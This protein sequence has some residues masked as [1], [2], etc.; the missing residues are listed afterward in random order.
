[1]G[2]GIPKEVVSLQA[3]AEQLTKQIN[4]LQQKKT[5]VMNDL[6]TKSQPLLKPLQEQAKTLLDERAKLVTAKQELNAQINAVDLK[7]API[8]SQRVAY[9]EVVKS[10]KGNGKGNNNGQVR[11]DVEACF[12]KLS[13]NGKVTKTA[14]AMALCELRGTTDSTNKRQVDIYCEVDNSDVVVAM[15]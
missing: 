8:Q 9:G 13:A 7:L 12:V 14:L 3:D 5:G 4:A 10:Q 15:K 1:M 11:R 2:N 6:A